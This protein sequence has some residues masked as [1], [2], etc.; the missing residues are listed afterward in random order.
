MGQ[1]RR[2][3]GSLRKAGGR[4]LVSE[5]CQPTGP[6]SKLLRQVKFWRIGQEQ[7]QSKIF[8]FL[9]NPGMA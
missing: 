1:F 7:L 4:R 6:G 2:G 3:S 9:P 8:D 5:S